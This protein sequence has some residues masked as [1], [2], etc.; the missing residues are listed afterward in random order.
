MSLVHLIHLA[1]VGVGRI[2]PGDHGTAGAGIVVLNDV[3]GDVGDHR[4]FGVIDRHGETGAGQVS[5]WIGGGEVDGSDSDR[6]GV[7]R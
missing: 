5:R 2:G 7:V 6:E 4:R 1:V 3:V